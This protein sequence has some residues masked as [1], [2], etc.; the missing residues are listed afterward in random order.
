MANQEI[1]IYLLPGLGV[2]YRLFQWIQFPKWVKPHYWSW[3][4]PK[5][6]ESLTSYSERYL[7]LIQK[8]RPTV[9]LGVSFGGVVAQE[10]ARM[11]SV[12]K[13]ILISSIKHH[14]ELPWYFFLGKAFPVHH[15]ISGQQI[16]II[17]AKIQRTLGD[18][19][20]GAQLFE[21]MLANTPDA[22]MPWAI[23]Q[24]IHWR[25]TEMSKNLVHYH[26]T[27]DHVLPS[28]YLSDF[29]PV[30][31]GTHAM[32]MVEAQQMNQILTKEMEN[33]RLQLGLTA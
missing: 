4:A 15:W 2:D 13:I 16:K 5:K 17:G 23:E 25:Q 32:I 10:I 22:F 21:R 8:N 6:K 19:G 30:A 27:N 33:L 18:R 31:G 26:G 12:E 1:H 7:P 28:S 9:L 14:H 3:E 29:I 20:K 11:I 24:L